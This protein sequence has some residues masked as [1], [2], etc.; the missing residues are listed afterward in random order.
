MKTLK[1]ILPYAVALT[2]PILVLAQVV[3]PLPSGTQSIVT[4][5]K[6]LVN[7]VIPILLI[8]GTVVFLWGVILYLTAGADEE[9][10]ANA[11]SLMIHGLVGLFVMVA[12]WGIVNVLVGFFGIT[13]TGIPE[14]PG[15][16][17][18]I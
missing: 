5:I 3:T 12:V 2:I 16:I 9:K 11:R 17:R 8:I 1:K 15:D 4:N 14:R 13:G 7:N 18:E 10:R 6:N